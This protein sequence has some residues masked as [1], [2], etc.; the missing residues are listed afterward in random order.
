ML[1]QYS[2][3]GFEKISYMEAYWSQVLLH[4]QFPNPRSANQ[5]LVRI[6]SVFSLLPERNTWSSRAPEPDSESHLNFIVHR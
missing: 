1:G 4:N 3:N 5:R 6:F 2:S